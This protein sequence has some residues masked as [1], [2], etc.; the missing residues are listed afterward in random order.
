MNH[1]TFTK[2]K[3]TN[4]RVV[5]CSC[6]RY[7]QKDTDLLYPVVYFMI[8]NVFLL[9]E[10]YITPRL[11]PAIKG[12]LTSASIIYY[13]TM[14]KWSDE[15]VCGLKVSRISYPRPQYGMM[16]YE[17]VMEVASSLC[18]ITHQMKLTASIRLRLSSLGGTYSVYRTR[19]PDR[20]GCSSVFIANR[21][22]QSL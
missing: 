10:S 11:V 15:W 13:M 12:I 18:L 5:M 8:R 17:F 7:W 6:Q 9:L 14:I 20:I 16:E 21:L 2:T 19:V 3:N 4:L 1:S 22:H